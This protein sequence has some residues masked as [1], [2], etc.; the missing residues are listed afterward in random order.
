MAADIIVIILL[1]VGFIDGWKN[2]LLTSIINLF[3]E[4][5][6]FILAYI[7]KGPLSL[8]LIEKLPFLDFNGIFKG[9]TSFNILIYEGIAFLICA[10]LISILIKILLKITGIISKAFN[11]TIILGLPNKLG[12]ALVSVIRFYIISFIV[13]FIISLIPKTSEIVLNS[14][15]SNNILNHTP[16][17]SNM[18][19][20]LN[21]TLSDLYELVTEIDNETKSEDINID[22]LEILLKYDIVSKETIEKLHD[23]GKLQ[24]KNFDDI[25]EK[26]N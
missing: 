23:S 25:I 7:L 2:G 18:T 15:I 3:K 26:Y 24:I 19:K 1:I 9:I 21:H 16:I 13:L 12:G 22:A 10:F 20:D 11:A 14:H 4:I 8:I 5:I 17:L 6:V